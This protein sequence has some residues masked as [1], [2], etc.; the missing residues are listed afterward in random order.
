MISQLKMQFVKVA[1]I[2][3]ALY[4]KKI[5]NACM[6]TILLVNKYIITDLEA[7]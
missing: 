6:H 4:L 7:H 2:E 3:I 5:A 1:Y